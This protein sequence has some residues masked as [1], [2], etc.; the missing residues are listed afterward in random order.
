MR[1]EIEVKRLFVAAAVLAM[2]FCICFPYLTEP[3]TDLEDAV[4]YWQDLAIEL[5]AE[6]TTL[7]QLNETLTY[8]N[9]TLKADL[10][11]AESVMSKLKDNV[12][13]AVALTI[14]AEALRV[15]ADADLTAAL[16][17]IKVLEELVKKLSGPRFGALVST[18]YTNGEYGLLAGVTMSLK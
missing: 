18:T 8:E 3:V 15:Q 13:E 17:Q 12:T 14:E 11:D 2:A 7:T 1:E 6:N 16:S 4:I 9:A 5:A 10:A